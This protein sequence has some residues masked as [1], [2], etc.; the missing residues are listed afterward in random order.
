MLLAGDIGGTKTELAIFD[1]ASGP[2]RPLARAE[3]PS[4]QYTDLPTLAREF[5]ATPAAIATGIGVRRACFDVAGPVLDGRAKVTNLPWRLDEI[6]LSGALGLES[7]HLL[8]DLHAIAIAVPGLG[9]GDVHTLNAVP[10]AP[11]GVIAV[12]A[13]GTGLGEAFLVPDGA[14]YRAFP[15][16]GGHASFAPT[17]PEEVELLNDLMKRVGHVSWER[18]C[19]GIG[20][21]NLYDHLRDRGH[22][23]E[24]P[25]LAAALAA[26]ADRTPLISAAGL[27][28]PEPDPL[29]AAALDLFVA[30]LAAEA[31]NL[32]LKVLATGGIYLAG[33][34]PVRLLPA[35]VEGRFMRQ[36]VRKGRFGELLAGL[37]VHV[38][39][40]RAALIGAATRGL[41]LAAA[42]GAADGAFPHS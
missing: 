25:E 11:G 30:I 28:Q 37:P 10:A 14:R 24:S 33:G 39:M 36:F 31:G 42:E 21:P 41:E 20:I 7:V 9:P 13:P 19:S 23:A 35:L 2:R 3:F 1:P 6:E 4:T 32:A 16:E 15:S 22:A 17:T 8:N 38:V 29:A 27:R 12:I 26:A 5:L 40:Q 34:L 18:V